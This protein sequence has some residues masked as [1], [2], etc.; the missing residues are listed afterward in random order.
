MEEDEEGMAGL[1]M[2]ENRGD[3]ELEYTSHGNQGTNLGNRDE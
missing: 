3:G 2:T 1:G